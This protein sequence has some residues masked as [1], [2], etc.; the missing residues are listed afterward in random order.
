MSDATAPV[1][2]YVQLSDEEILANNPGLAQFF[3]MIEVSRILLHAVLVIVWCKDVNICFSI[4]LPRT[5]KKYAKWEK[6]EVPQLVRN[7]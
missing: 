3:E 2:S 4:P 6:E 1:E 7:E 5:R